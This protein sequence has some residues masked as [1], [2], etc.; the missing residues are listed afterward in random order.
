MPAN[1]SLFVQLLA[2]HERLHAFLVQ[3]VGLCKVEHVELDFE[4]SVGAPRLRTKEEPLLVRARI[5][6]KPHQQV[7]LIIAVIKCP[8]GAVQVARLKVRVEL[9]CKR[10]FNRVLS[11]QLVQLKLRPVKLV[12]LVV[13][14]H[15]AREPFERLVEGRVPRLMLER[16][17]LHCY[18]GFLQL[19]GCLSEL[20]LLHLN[21]LVRIGVVQLEGS[22]V[23]GAQVKD[24]LRLDQVV[25]IVLDQAV[26]ER[27]RRHFKLLV[28]G[29]PP[30]QGVRLHGALASCKSGL[31][32]FY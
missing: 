3:R 14:L 12:P 15:L 8:G 27:D 26:T 21:R 1:T 6:V 17:T 2:P 7:V 10:I 32:G 5:R 20:H 23:P 30:K 18:K 29:F 13:L 28:G 19:L 25:L 22:L 31:L 24:F 4:A 11:L 16:V 9:E